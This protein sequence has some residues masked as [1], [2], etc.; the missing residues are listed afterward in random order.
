MPNKLYWHSLALDF[1]WQHLFAAAPGWVR[2]LIK[3]RARFVFQTLF[4][5]QEKLGNSVG[6]GRG[7][8]TNSPASKNTNCLQAISRR[9]TVPTQGTYWSGS[10]QFS[11]HDLQFLPRVSYWYFRYTS[12]T[13]SPASGKTIGVEKHQTYEIIKSKLREDLKLPIFSCS[14]LRNSCD[15]WLR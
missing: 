2:R 9:K 7:N 1:C 5:S 11:M 8:L 14:K 3:V 10:H 6:L 15:H 13:I 4:S 12:Y